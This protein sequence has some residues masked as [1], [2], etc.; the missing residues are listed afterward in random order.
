MCILAI[1]F[2]I[3]P[4]E[5]WKSGILTEASLLSEK[6]AVIRM[7]RQ[8]GIRSPF[9]WND[10]RI[11][12]NIKLLSRLDI[13]SVAFSVEGDRITIKKD[14]ILS[15]NPKAG[16]SFV[17]KVDI[18]FEDY[19]TMLIEFV[20]SNGG[21]STT[22]GGGTNPG[23]GSGTPGGGS[24]GGTPSSGGSTPSGGGSAPSGGSST[25]GGNPSAEG[26]AS[27]VKAIIS[28]ETLNSSE[29]RSKDYTIN[30]SLASIT[31]D[32]QAM[33][34]IA[35]EAAS[36]VTVTV[37][38][39]DA[40]ELSDEA[41][42]VVG[43]RPVYDF[44]IASGDK[45]ISQFG[46]N[47]TVTLPYTPKEGEDINAI[48]IYYINAEGKPEVVTNCAYDPATGTISF[49]TN[50]FSKY[51]IG[52]NKVVFGDVPASAWYSKAVTF[53]AAREITTG[54]GNGNFSPEAK[55]TRGQFMVLL[56]R[57][58]GI[59]PDLNPADN[60][61][62][63]GNT[64]Y[65]G[66]LAAAKRLGIT[67]GIGSNLFGPEKEITRQEMFTLLYNTLKLLNLLPASGSS[68]KTL[69]DFS[70]S[71]EI[72]AWAK[73]AMAYLVEAGI[74]SGSNGKLMPN[75]TTTRAEMAQVLYN[76]LSR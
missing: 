60:F 45:V 15:F 51:G 31:L 22:P 43:D 36:D 52:Y 73:E 12:R 25:S 3:T 71:G 28:K 57:A 63:A 40:D 38:R 37:T 26:S 6:S 19:L 8:A 5:K 1:E 70:D 62:D 35:G 72:A 76:L 29:S 66:Y 55:L 48:V 18:A 11:I 21:G 47:V 68:G 54:T 69:A 44:K 32:S 13:P 9:T 14:D 10:L 74:I 7:L 23:G 61:A 27:T 42:K 59:A 4:P 46:G 41:K 24:S 39:V 2:P 34:V 53:I 58:Y 30:T 17:L 49:T 56:M 75:S 50:H 16:E 64:Y 67:R 20:D 65:T 33:S